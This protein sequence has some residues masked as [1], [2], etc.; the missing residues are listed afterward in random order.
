MRGQE[1]HFYTS[2]QCKT[3]GTIAPAPLPAHSMAPCSLH[4]R[5]VMPRHS[6]AESGTA[7]LSTWVSQ[8][9]PDFTSL[10]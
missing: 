8:N 5:S 6:S 2:P 1:I 9:P 7:W 10:L 3:Q 4:S